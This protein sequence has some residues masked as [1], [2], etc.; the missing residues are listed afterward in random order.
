MSEDAGT[1]LSK[2][3]PVE[4]ALMLKS[5]GPDLEY[6]RRLVSSYRQFNADGLPMFVVVP[7]EDLGA[8]GALAGD[9]VQVL[10]ESLLAEHLTTEWIS[11]FSPGYMNQQIVKLA[12]WELGLADN[13]LCMDSDA[14]FLRPFFRTDFMAAPGVPFAFLTEDTELRAEP[15]Y[16]REHWAVREPKLRLIQQTVGL[17][18]DRLLTCHQHAVFSAAVLRSF[19]D[20]FLLPRG[21][22]YADVL[23]ISPY[24]FSW[25]NM[26][27]QKDLTVPLVMREPIFKTFHNASQ[28]LEYLL[29]GVTN[30]D[31]ARGY[32]GLVIN[33]NYSRGG[34]VVS[35]DDARYESL[36]SYVPVSDLVKAAAYGAW[37]RATGRGHPISA[38]RTKVGAL[39]GRG[40]KPDA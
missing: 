29:R 8:F 19:R 23:A 24:E 33:S 2:A 15:E 10:S 31:V 5:Y 37:W 35:M 22:G 9:D 27:W 25:Y 26:W 20:T 11:G 14:V 40:P 1:G 34:G 30:E 3:Q 12:F 21:M 7:D 4:L 17:E 32:V 38:L 28:H 13:Y 16:F 6:A 18:S 36:A 39:L